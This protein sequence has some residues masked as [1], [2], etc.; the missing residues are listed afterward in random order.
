MFEASRGVILLL[1]PKGWTCLYVPRCI[2]GQA[3][4]IH[5]RGLPVLVEAKQKRAENPAPQW[6]HSEV[7]PLP[8]PLVRQARATAPACNHV[9]RR[10][11]RLSGE[12]LATRS[13]A[14]QCPTLTGA[15]SCRSV[16][17]LSSVAGGSALNLFSLLGLHL[18]TLAF[19]SLSIEETVARYCA[20]IHTHTNTDTLESS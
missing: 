16:H 10:S 15:F 2:L 9:T 6:H 12:L 19:C 14:L 13:S 3:K 5:T 7:N 18:A 8:R 11:R 1:L 20:V 4:K 17:S